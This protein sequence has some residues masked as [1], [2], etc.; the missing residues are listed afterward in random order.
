MG[1]EASIIKDESLLGSF[2]E[3]GAVQ[4]SQVPG[5][6]GRL[7]EPQRRRKESVTKSCIALID[8]GCYGG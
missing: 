5:A 8:K 7:M 1:V 2:S 6:S 4:C 3:P